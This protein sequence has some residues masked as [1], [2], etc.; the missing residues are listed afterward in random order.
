[1]KKM[2]AAAEKSLPNYWSDRV[3]AQALENPIFQGALRNKKMEQPLSKKENRFRLD[4]NELPAPIL[5]DTDWY[6][7]SKHID[8]NRYDSDLAPRL[9]GLIARHYGLKR[10]SVLLEA[11]GDG[12]LNL[13]FNYCAHKKLTVFI[14]EPAYGGFD[15]IS[16]VVQCPTRKY[17]TLDRQLGQKPFDVSQLQEGTA[18]LLCNPD[19]PT[20][21]IIPEIRGYLENHVQPVIVDEAYIDFSPGISATKLIKEGIPRVIVLGTFSKAFGA[22]SVRL[23]YVIAHPRLIEELSR[24]QLRYPV[25]SLAV[26]MGLQ[27]WKHRTRMKQNVR[28]LQKACQWLQN[29][30]VDLGFNVIPSKMNF[31]SCTLPRD[32]KFKE[33]VDKLRRHH[34]Y[35]QIFD[36]HEEIGPLIRVTTGKQEENEE[37]VNRLKKIL[38]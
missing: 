25:S 9:T 4:L 21:H 14:P 22:A 16:S 2:P 29:R 20:G 19:N 23:G 26:E 24:Y 17:I 28:A 15:F 37:L 30:F 1:M 8:I 36:F 11:G 33:F 18:L 35:V 5:E 6:P 7:A 34:I 10:E 32:V 31:F 12:A 3:K 38:G 13:V 27:L